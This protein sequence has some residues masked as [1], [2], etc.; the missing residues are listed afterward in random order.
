MVNYSNFEMADMHFTHGCTNGNRKEFMLNSTQNVDYLIILRSQIF[1]NSCGNLVN[2]KTVM[3]LAVPE[4]SE[5][6][7]SKMTYLI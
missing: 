2:L 7:L 6:K 1:T 4:K 5:P 3:T